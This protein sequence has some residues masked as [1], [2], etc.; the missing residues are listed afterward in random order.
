MRRMVCL[1]L[2]GVGVTSVAQNPSALPERP[3]KAAV[4]GSRWIPAERAK[5]TV[6]VFVTR[7]CP[8]ANRYMPELGRIAT[9]YAKRGVWLGLAFEDEETSAQAVS[10]HVKSFRATMPFFIDEGHRVAR[11]VGATVTPECA[12]VDSAGKV[13][14][15][16]RIDGFFSGNGRVGQNNYR[17]DLR[18]SLDALL[19][20]KPVPAPVVDAKGCFIPGLR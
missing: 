2:A 18:L 19:A 1:F 20:G 7:S 9:E 8:I 15:R 14:Y 10:K 16:G 13:R 5:L 11:A 12:I 6:V 4:G 3:I 17:R